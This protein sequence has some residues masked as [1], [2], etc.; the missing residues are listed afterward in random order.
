MFIASTSR[1]RT[2]LGVPCLKMVFANP[3]S[4]AQKAKSP[5][6]QFGDG[7]SAF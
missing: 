7:S 4:F 5:K 6:R 1:E 3:P 2:P